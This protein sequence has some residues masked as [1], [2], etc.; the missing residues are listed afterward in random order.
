MK[1]QIIEKINKDWEEVKAKQS[2]REKMVIDGK[3]GLGIKTDIE[4]EEHAKANIDETRDFIIRTLKA[5]GATDEQI[6]RLCG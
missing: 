1:K 2:K 4:V 6:I 3:V 5:L